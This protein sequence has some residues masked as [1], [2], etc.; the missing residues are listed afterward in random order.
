VHFAGRL[1][2]RSKQTQDLIQ[3]WPRQFNPAGKI[4]CTFFFK[5]HVS[6]C[7][8]QCN[9][10]GCCRSRKSHCNQPSSDQT[11]AISALRSKRLTTTALIECEFRISGHTQKSEN[12]ETI[13]EKLTTYSISTESFRAV[14]AGLW[15]VW[16]FIV[17]RGQK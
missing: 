15:P 14:V 12:F 7:G 5:H 8:Q 17:A 2:L 16:L 6:N 3:W 1:N 11:V 13:Q 10:T 4:P 9:S